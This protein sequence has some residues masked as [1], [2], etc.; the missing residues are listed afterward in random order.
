MTVVYGYVHLSVLQPKGDVIYAVF[1]ARK[2][3][4]N[5]YRIYIGETI[6]CPRLE[7]VDCVTE[8]KSK[9]LK[10]VFTETLAMTERFHVLTTI[11]LLV[12]SCI[13]NHVDLS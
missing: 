1:G 4:Y 9:R 6:I 5:V 3:K 13:Q 11:Q 8:P 7:A 12:R 10:F 2:L